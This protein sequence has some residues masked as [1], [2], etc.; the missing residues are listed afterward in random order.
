LVESPDIA[1]EP[2]VGV[3]A[4]RRLLWVIVICAIVG[5]GAAYA[6]AARSPNQYEATAELLFGA[7][8]SLSQL[9]GL[10]DV[11]SSQEATAATATDVELASL[12]VLSNL[13]AAALGRDAPPGGISVAVAEAGASNLVNVTATNTSPPLA[14]RIANLYS[15]QFVSYTTSQQAAAVTADIDA[16][17]RQI[18]AGRSAG[19]KP[20]ELAAMQTT[21][22]Q[23]RTIA[24]VEPVDVSVAETATPPTSPSSPHPIEEGFL[25]LLI[26]AVIGVA[27]AVL[28]TGVDPR[29][30]SLGT[31]GANDTRS[32][33]TWEEKVKPLSRRSGVQTPQKSALLALRLATTGARAQHEQDDSVQI[34]VT[35]SPA[36]G[37]LVTAT[38]LAWDLACSAATIGHE[39]SVALVNVGKGQFDLAGAIEPGDRPGWV[40]VIE[41]SASLKD[42]IQSLTVLG[43]PADG[44]HVD[45]LLAR[46]GS[47]L[48]LDHDVQV[49]SF[50]RE[51]ASVYRYVVVAAPS[52]DEL[53]PPSYLVSDADAVFAVARVHRSRRRDVRQLLDALASQRASGVFL[54]GCLDRKASGRP[55]TRT[56]TSRVGAAAH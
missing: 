34:L 7:N 39:S 53:G 33:I 6:K 28:A 35:S 13:T 26:G 20:S 18:R 8:S 45:V 27:A 19:I 48:Y 11:T 40:D 2:R 16:L 9:L 21:L 12:P 46:Q 14:A 29:L 4:V 50:L 5:A 38:A 24:T 31:V 37:D 41:G 30:H 32:V 42:A 3:A 44:R 49:R 17:T 51:L 22:A 36:R 47:E 56:H 25:G 1:K 52:A 23:L 15:Q 55:M 10:P 43:D 54:I